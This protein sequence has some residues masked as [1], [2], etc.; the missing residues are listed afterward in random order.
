[1]NNEIKSWTRLDSQVLG[2]YRIFRLKR[3]TS[4]S[5]RTGQEHDFFVLETG[6]WVNMAQ[7]R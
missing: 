2:D 5:P 6:D 3:D 7:K 1:M 4:R